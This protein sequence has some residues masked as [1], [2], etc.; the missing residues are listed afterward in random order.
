MFHC[1]LGV[2]VE[3]GGALTHVHISQPVKI[4]FGSSTT[5]AAHGK[6]R[7]P[8]ILKWIFIE[9]HISHFSEHWLVAMPIKMPWFMYGVN[10]YIECF[11]HFLC[12]FQP[13]A[14]TQI[15]CNHSVIPYH[16]ILL[17]LWM[18]KNLILILNQHQLLLKLT[19][20]VALN[21]FVLFL[22]V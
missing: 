4:I 8:N 15:A 19:L 5:D 1:L 3:W 17:A 13:I 11:V 20:T 22:T 2:E 9:N 14:N 10:D 7:E 6:D 16:C 21:F 12:K 18:R